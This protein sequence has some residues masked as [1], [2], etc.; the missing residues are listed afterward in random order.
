MDVQSGNGSA[1]SAAWPAAAAGETSAE[2][3]EHGGALSRFDLERVRHI[4]AE[5]AEAVRAAE[6]ALQVRRLQQD[7]YQ[8][9]LELLA[10]KYQIDVGRQQIDLNTGQIVP[11]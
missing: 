9:C 2:M 7:R 8:L 4:Q 6:A 11:M 5:L 1:A 3:R 10:G